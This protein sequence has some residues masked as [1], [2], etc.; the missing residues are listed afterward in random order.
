M[1]NTWWHKQLTNL[2]VMQLCNHAEFVNTARSWEQI[3]MFSKAEMKS[4][5]I[6]Q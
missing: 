5:S 2:G 6:K 1:I 3:Q 4:K